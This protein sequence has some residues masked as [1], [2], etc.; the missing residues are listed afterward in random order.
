MGI[1]LRYEVPVLAV[2][3]VTDVILTQV[4]HIGGGLHLAGRVVCELAGEPVLRV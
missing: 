2:R 4:I 1:I 3:M